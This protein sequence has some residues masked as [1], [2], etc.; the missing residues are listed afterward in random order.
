MPG[1]QQKRKDGDAAG[2][3]SNKRPKLLES[4]VAQ[5]VFATTLLLK[6]AWGTL[7]APDLQ[8]LAMACKLAGNEEAEVD[9]LA[10]LGAYGTNKG[11]CHR[12]LLRRFC[13]NMLAPEPNRFCVP[14][15]DPKGAAEVAIVVDTSFYLAS[16]WFRALATTP[17]LQYEYQTV[18]GTQKLKNFWDHQDV[19]NDPKFKHHP[20]FHQNN[21]KNK[22]IP[23]ILHGDGAAFALNDSLLTLSFAGVLK[24]GRTLDTNLFLAS[25]PKSCTAKGDRGTWYTIWCWIV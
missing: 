20:V 15:R 5:S 19:R 17:D 11:S 3:G 4:S 18:F 6:W 25:W 7:T 24:E 14:A 12:D 9:E 8:E 23:V 21:Y 13:S 10:S 22:A 1:H 16:D 2:S